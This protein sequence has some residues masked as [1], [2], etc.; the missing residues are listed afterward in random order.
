MGENRIAEI[1]PNDFPAN[2]SKLALE[3]SGYVDAGMKYMALDM[4]GE[5]LQNERISPFEFREV[6]RAIGVYADEIDEWTLQIESAYRQQSAKFRDCVRESMLDFYCSIKDWEKAARFIRLRTLNEPPD[7]FFAMR[8]LLQLDQLDRAERILVKCHSFQAKPMSSF[9]QHCLIEACASYYAR[10]G[11]WEHAI[12]LWRIAPK[13]EAWARDALINIVE[14]YAARAL[15]EAN[16]GLAVL[17]EARKEVDLEMEI[18]LPGNDD[19]MDDDWERDLLK[20]K[21]A[22]EDI[23]PEE[24][25]KE[26]GLDIEK[27]NQ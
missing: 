24:R 15:W 17:K 27:Q 14:M 9:H 16:K 2:V 20:L 13:E 23:L 11:E 12:H 25:R 10:I 1:Q 4:A 8:V 19:S 6:I 7:L 18:T 21:E 26:L 22:L 3:L 5:I